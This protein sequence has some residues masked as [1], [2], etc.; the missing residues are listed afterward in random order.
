MKISE[1]EKQSVVEKLTAFIDQEGKATRARILDGTAKLYGLS[2]KELANKSP[3]SKNGLIRSYIGT[4]LNDLVASGDVAKQND[5][6]FLTKEKLIVVGT[7]QYKKEILRLLGRN[8]MK[9]KDLYSALQNH[10]GTVQTKSLKDDNELKGIAGQLLTQMLSEQKVK[11]E[12][13]LYSL[14]KEADSV[15]VWKEFRPE[16][17][18][19]KAFFERIHLKG[20]AFFERYCANLLEKYYQMTGRAV[21]SCEVTGGSMDGGVDIEMVTVDDLGFVEHLMIQ[22]KCRENTQ[23]TEKE[24]RE[25][26]GAVNVKNGSRGIFLTSGSFHPSA[27]KLLKSIPNCVGIDRERLYRLVLLTAYGI[28][29]SASGCSFDELI[30]NS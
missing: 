26:W 22:T 24:I 15:A 3:N 13:D 30:F 29:K 10:F 1:K 19:Q 18:F 9:K 21:S 20:G 2:E 5:E 17:E 12:G 28:V 7:Q 23:T 27:E 11:L 8:P 14:P 6:Y 4:A 16:A 25:F